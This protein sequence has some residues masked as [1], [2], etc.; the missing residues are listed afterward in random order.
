MNKYEC[1]IC[2][3]FFEGFGNNPW[4]ATFG[5][6]DRCC[7]R[8]NMIAVLPARIAGLGALVND[9][10]VS[11]VSEGVRKLKKRGEK[12]DDIEWLY[13]RLLASKRIEFEKWVSAVEEIYGEVL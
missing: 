13:R 1:S 2:G 12:P 8:C 10:I 7:D 5:E 6:N 9:V 4:P 3:Q 11:P